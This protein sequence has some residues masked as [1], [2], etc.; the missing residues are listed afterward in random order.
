MACLI[1]CLLIRNTTA[2]LPQLEVFSCS[3]S[4]I[5]GVRFF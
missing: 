4:M 5:S 3:Y 1:F 2:K